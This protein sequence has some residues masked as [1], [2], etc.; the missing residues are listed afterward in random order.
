[1]ARAN[2]IFLLTILALAVAL[3]GCTTGNGTQSTPT[4][5]EGNG[6][7]IDGPD[8]HPLNAPDASC[9]EINEFQNVVVSITIEN[10]GS[11]EIKIPFDMRYEFGGSEAFQSLSASVLRSRCPSIF[12]A[13]Q[14]S[15]SVEKVTPADVYTYEKERGQTTATIDPGFLSRE[16]LPSSILDFLESTGILPE[17][18]TPTANLVLQPGHRLELEWVMRLRDADS[19]ESGFTCPLSFELKTIHDVT[20]TRRIQVKQDRDVQDLGSFT[21]RSSAAPMDMFIDA[22]DS[23]VVDEDRFPVQIYLRNDESG[24]PSQILQLQSTDIVAE[25][26]GNPLLECSFQPDENSR[27]GE[28]ELRTLQDGSGETTRKTFLCDAL[29]LPGGTESQT[30]I[31]SATATF[32]Y[33]YERQT[34]DITICKEGDRC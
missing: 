30:A 6:L 21:A 14:S 31:L 32:F 33:S 23:W 1:M 27:L 20:A 26:G 25:T 3:A 16:E 19:L 4:E 12:S 22:P 24:S 11:N 15:V 17:S 28:R 29:Q 13:R 9:S 8:C 5:S 10:T 2:N 7:Q 34:I 18:D